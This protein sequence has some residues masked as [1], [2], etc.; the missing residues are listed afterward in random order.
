MFRRAPCLP[1]RSRL[2]LALA[3]AL[4]LL[5]CDRRQEAAPSP[6]AT[7]AT[8]AAGGPGAAAA[9]AS[10]PSQPMVA[11][12]RSAEDRRFLDDL[13]GFC[14]ITQ[15]VKTDAAIDP[16]DRARV[17]VERL[18]ARKPSPAFL[19]L[20]RSMSSRSEGGERYAALKE[21]ATA[22]GAPAWSCPDLDD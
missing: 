11:G 6:P 21:A 8:A 7:Q 17:L 12:P 19:E 18:V 15:Q 14:I 20:L 9:S 2:S 13:N 4:F 3:G 10:A 5:A 16:K 1:G 22:H